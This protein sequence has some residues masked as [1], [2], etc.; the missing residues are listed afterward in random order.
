MSIYTRIFLIAAGCWSCHVQASC[1][2]SQD[3]SQ[4]GPPAKCKQTVSATHIQP[5]DPAGALILVG[6]GEVP[7]EIRER[8]AKGGSAGKP[9][10]CLVIIPTSST[11][12]DTESPDYWKEPW[13]DSGFES[14]E[15][16]HTRDRSQA[17]TP[18]FNEP[19]ARATAVWVS[20]GDQ[21]LFTAAYGG[22]RTEAMLKKVLARGGVVSGTS[23][24][25]AMASR[26]MIAEGRD[27]PLMGTGLDLLPLGIVDQHFANRNRIG[28]LKQAVAKHPQCVG[29]GIDEATAAIFHR[30]SLTIMG[31]GNVRIVMAATEFAPEETRVLKRGTQSLDWTTI[32]RESRERALPPFPST[33]R[34]D[35]AP[36]VKNGALLMVGG[37]EVTREMW[38]VFVARAGG[39]QANI[40]ILP[41]GMPMPHSSPPEAK[42]IRQMGVKNVTVL[43][44]TDRETVNSREYRQV[45]HAATGI[46]FGGGRQWRF[47]DAYEGSEVLKSM[48]SCLD[49]G[50]IIGGNSAGASIQ[51]DLLCRGAPAGNHI[52]VQDGYRRGFGF[53][54]GV[55][56]DQ[57]FS[58]RSRLPDLK[59]VIYKYPGVL[60]L[61]IDEGTAILVERSKA[62]VIGSGEVFAISMQDRADSLGQ[63]ERSEEQPKIGN[64]GNSTIALPGQKLVRA[65]QGQA[66]D[67]ATLELV[68]E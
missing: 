60:G 45:L 41:T 6:G 56:I 21:S 32:V 68:S 13:L 23:A 39:Q 19:L 9:G 62:K 26:V 55:T 3:H 22:T 50:G 12:A 7:A 11:Y 16:L 17:D 34:N 67:L 40:V 37:G 36:C 33:N 1:V 57:H 48:R 30:R 5:F 54:P 66:I 53:L 2:A 59:Q 64:G 31:E 51:A 8:I 25:A 46:W 15:I 14:I 61:G 20:G 4:I 38:D 63:F 44:A 18:A 29:I 35:A 10:S 28:R 65:R 58:Q 42:M 27:V 52:L 24:G 47:V 43:P 49:R